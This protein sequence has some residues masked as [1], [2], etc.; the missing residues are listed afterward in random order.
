MVMHPHFFTACIEAFHNNAGLTL[1]KHSDY[2]ID[3]CYIA[4]SSWFPQGFH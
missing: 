2:L 1:L 3:L 4:G